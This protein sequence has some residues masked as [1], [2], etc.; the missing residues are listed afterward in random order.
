MMSIIV[1]VQ[2]HDNDYDV[3]MFSAGKL[4]D[5]VTVH[6]LQIHSPQRFNA[7][8]ILVR[9]CSAC[10]ARWKEYTGPKFQISYV[11]KFDIIIFKDILST[12]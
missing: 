5:F 1:Y 10:V 3:L 7:N 12:T 11:H 8:P 2:K 4:T 9:S 6:T